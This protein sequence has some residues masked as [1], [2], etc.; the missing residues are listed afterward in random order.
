MYPVSG[1]YG[2]RTRTIDETID[3][4]IGITLVICDTQ[5]NFNNA[6]IKVTTISG[7]VR[8]QKSK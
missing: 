4:T 5:G 1:K 3:E 6:C 2:V 8:P 7:E